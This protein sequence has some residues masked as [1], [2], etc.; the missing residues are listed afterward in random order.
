MIFG[1]YS[2]RDRLTGYSQPT[3]DQNDAVAMR[4][5]RHAF[6][7]WQSIYHSHPGDFEL[8]KLGMFDSDSG[9]LSPV[10]VTPI[11]SG[12]SIVKEEASDAV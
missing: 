5:F 8:C 10:Q 1:V 11:M 2:I 4:N 3:I 6:M 12:V 9:L 7:N